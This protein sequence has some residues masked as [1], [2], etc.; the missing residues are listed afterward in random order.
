MSIEQQVRSYILEGL[1][2]SGPK[3]L[4]TDDYPLIENDV[5][6]S[7]GIMQLVTWIESE[8]DI[9]IDDDDLAPENFETVATIAS[10]VESSTTT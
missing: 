8:F 9:E 10:L 4:L 3:H 7:V 6:D 5:L 2:W 1:A